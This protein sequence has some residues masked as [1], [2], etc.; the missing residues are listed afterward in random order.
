MKNIKFLSACFLV[1]FVSLW[2]M[3]MINRE[4]EIPPPP[5]DITPVETEQ[6]AQQIVQGEIIYY[7]KIWYEQEIVN[8]TDVILP[9]NNSNPAYFEQTVFVGDSNTEGLA[10]FEH[11]AYSNVIGKHS[12]PVQGVCR[13]DYQLVAED[14][15]ETEEDESQYI[16]MLQVLAAK[17][18]ARIILNF[19]TNNAGKDA[20]AEN[21]AYMY[22][23]V[24]S[25]IEAYCPYTEIVIASVL[26]VCYERDYYKIRQDSIDQFNIQL[27]A[28]CR[29]KG[30][31]FLNYTEVFKDSESGYAKDAFFSADGV[32]LNGDGYRLLL[33]YA[34]NHQYNKIN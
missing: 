7:D 1:G 5:A 31:G 29:E 13:D 18:P 23:Q 9:Y 12:M 20:D 32:H 3:T 30:Y 4:T 24:L 14:N 15:P 11:I 8:Y 34:V 21:F 6:P 10:L 16:T 33:D 19:G 17:Q 27:A 22:E 25:Q 28:I 26:P 2:I